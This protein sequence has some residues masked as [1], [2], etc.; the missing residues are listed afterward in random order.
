LIEAAFGAAQKPYILEGKEGRE[1]RLEG[2]ALLSLPP[3][4]APAVFGGPHGV[5][6]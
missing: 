6:L 5:Q 1:A 4:W 2:L 3:P